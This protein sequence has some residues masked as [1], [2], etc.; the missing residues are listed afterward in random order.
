MTIKWLD[1]EE[2]ERLFDVTLMDWAKQYGYRGGYSGEETRE[3]MVEARNWAKA[4][5][6]AK[7]VL[8]FVL[9]SNKTVYVVGMR[10]G[11]QCFN[12]TEGPN[13]DM[14]VVFI[15]LQGRLTSNVRTAHNIHMDPNDC[16]GNVVQVNNNIALL[17]EFG[18]AKQWMETPS[19]FDNVAP[20]LAKG[21]TAP[22]YGLASQAKGGGQYD[23]R[24]D[25][26][27]FAAAI[28]AKAH[29]RAADKSNVPTAQEVQRYNEETNP[30][31]YKPPVW[32][33]KIEM[34]NMSRHEWPICR[35]LG[36]PLREN[37]RDINATS[38]GDPSVSSQIRRKAAVQARADAT[39]K[40]VVPQ[41]K[42]MGKVVCPR[43]QKT[44]FAR[45]VD[46]PCDSFLHG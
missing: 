42:A 24:L 26:S 13:H 30:T 4:S 34:D 16:T 45:N 41:S 19:M 39:L 5:R 29:G 18:H 22:K 14:P 12:S 32:G 33:T 27:E 35:E 3:K 40:T 7:S 43:C 46:K 31:G 9:L 21:V 2:A 10:G 1:E 23:A 28:Q 6:T 17:H 25:K 36:L 44:V 20:K 37:Y 15:D 11:Y 38:D 8:D